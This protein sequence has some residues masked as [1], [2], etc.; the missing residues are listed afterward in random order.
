MM[1]FREGR[2][3]LLIFSVSALSLLGASAKPPLNPT[4]KLLKHPASTV[5]PECDEGVAPQP[6]PRIEIAEIR[7]APSPA[8]MKTSPSASLRGQLT[9]AQNAALKRDRAGFS[10]ALARAKE[11]LQSYP[12]GAE[13]TAAAEVVRVDED[14]DRLW[15]YEFEDP[16]GA[17]F[18]ASNPLL[19][20]LN[21][22]PAYQKAIAD[23]VLVVH[24]T[25]LYPTR[26]SRD[27][28]VREAAARL[29]KLSGGKAPAQLVTSTTTKPALH[30]TTMHPAVVEDKSKPLPRVKPKGTTIV[31]VPAHATTHTPAPKHKPVK[32]AKV[33]PPPPAR[34]PAPVPVTTTTAPPPA[35]V[36]V[37]APVTTTTAATTTVATTTTAPP[38]APVPAVATATTVTVT[39]PTTD[40]T[41][42]T[43]SAEPPPKP[44]TP[45][46][47]PFRSVVLPIILI[48]IGIG[49]LIVLFRASS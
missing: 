42:T 34:V 32:V 18:D 46:S 6:T 9:D 44:A 45:A 27:F 13:R 21:A 23:Q 7:E 30:R 8:P 19:A 11:T 38:P 20:M 12:P 35:P 1:M 33:S 10:D 14:I 39:T 25:K 47:S 15:K 16:S 41:V 29:A 5:P 24:G 43:A 49:V 3:G 22:Y 26:E 40:T 48:V 4:V 2:A 31:H 28:L 36:P 17:F 37:P